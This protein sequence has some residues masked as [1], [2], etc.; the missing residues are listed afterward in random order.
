MA[1]AKR[2]LT[3]S[4][5]Q[6]ELLMIFGESTAVTKIIQD[7]KPYEKTQYPTALHSPR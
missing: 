7:E 2:P 1:E 4:N 3:A 5:R 6:R